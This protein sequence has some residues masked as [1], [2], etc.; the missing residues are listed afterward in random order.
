MG[1]VLDVKEVNTSERGSFFFFCKVLDSKEGGNAIYHSTAEGFIERRDKV[2][3]QL[4]QAHSKESAERLRRRP[5]GEWL[6]MPRA[7]SRRQ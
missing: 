5:Q 7:E 6:A 1:K 4:S 3:L 2:Q